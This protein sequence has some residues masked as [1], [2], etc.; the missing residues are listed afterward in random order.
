MS[1]ESDDPTRAVSV[2]SCFVSNL[3]GSHFLSSMSPHLDS[4]TTIID[5]TLER[6]LDIVCNDHWDAAKHD[7]LV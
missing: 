5:H 3:C 4:E 2:S 7:C 6:Q 1:P